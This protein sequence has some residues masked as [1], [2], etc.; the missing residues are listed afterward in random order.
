MS[1]QPPATTSDIVKR[2]VRLAAIELTLGV[3][4]CRSH[5]QFLLGAESFTID[6][7]RICG[8]GSSPGE[9]SVLDGTQVV[10][11]RRPD[12]PPSFVAVA[13]TSQFA[14]CLDGNTSLEDASLV[15]IDLKSQRGLAALRLTFSE[16]IDQHRETAVRFR[17][18]WNRVRARQAEKKR[19]RQATQWTA[20]INRV[21][22]YVVGLVAFR[23]NERQGCLE[24]DEFL[25]I[26]QPHIEPGEALKTLLNEVLARARDYTGSLNLIFTRDTRED[27]FG[28]IPDTQAEAPARRVPAAIPPSL[29]QFAERNAIKF[30]DGGKV[31]HEEALQLWLAVSG[32]S[33]TTL[34]RIVES[35]QAGFIGR[36]IVAEV[37]STDV[38]S[39]TEVAWL[40]NNASRPEGIVIGSD[41]PEDRLFYL[42]SLNWGRAVILTRRFRQAVLADLTQ[43]Q[44]TEELERR[45]EYCSLKPSGEMWQLQSNIPFRLPETWL[46]GQSSRGFQIPAGALLNILSLPRWHTRLDADMSWIAREVQRLEE[47]TTAPSTLLLSYEFRAREDYAVALAPIAK[48]SALRGVHL[49]FA[50]TRMEV[51][52]DRDIERRMKRARALRRFP[53]RDGPLPL[54]LFSLEPIRALPDQALWSRVQEA[55]RDARTFG[56]RLRQVRDVGH[57]RQEFS[58]SCDLIERTAAEHGNS[59]ADL[60]GSDSTKFVGA[61]RESGPSRIM[62][63]FVDGTAISP[64]LV[65]ILPKVKEQTAGFVVIPRSWSRFVAAPPHKTR[66]LT[67]VAF[68]NELPY[69]AKQSGSDTRRH[70]QVRNAREAIVHAVQAGSPLGAAA[71]RSDVLIE[72]IREFIYTR[73]TVQPLDLA[74]AYGDGTQGE[75]FP[76]FSL[77]PPQ[78]M[79]NTENFFDLPIGIISMRHLAVD[80]FT[81]RAIIRNLEIQFPA[82][83]TAAEQEE[84]AY[85]RTLDC[86]GELVRFFYEAENEQHLSNALRAFIWR[87]PE[88]EAQRGS[89]LR[90]QLFHS[91]ELEAASLGAYRAV[92]SLLIKYR[93]SLAVVPRILAPG[94]THLAST[95]TESPVLGADDYRAG[96]AWY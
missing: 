31:N 28:K 13:F 54:T 26:D 38:W 6:G 4:L 25:P 11:A 56:A 95:E 62:F 63:P 23:L 39:S 36:D 33:A 34:Q 81:E 71:F 16:W 77:A 59:I 91:T 47:Q 45:D 44:S 84:L 35:E 73:P 32:L 12:L 43:G 65:E 58:L 19:G 87:H 20:V 40:F 10:R 29:L 72:A 88:V 49:L 68:A 82:K 8:L 75:P 21:V 53:P 93:G 37:I 1:S 67:P 2:R 46:L 57:C 69:P 22:D 64:A 52:L 48:A 61:M 96:E 17:V 85:A 5:R 51:F 55:M 27:T 83:E 94:A 74:V 89:A 86:I 18:A 66:R 41:V 14:L 7:Y 3:S 70:E 42:D 60:A 92:L 30:A 79:N 80:R 76:L 78:S 9:L 90:V 24:I 50:P 15:Q